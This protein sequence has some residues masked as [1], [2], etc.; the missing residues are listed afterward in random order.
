M[1]QLN[2]GFNPRCEISD[3][4]IFEEEFTDEGNKVMTKV[5]IVSRAKMDLCL[6]IY[7]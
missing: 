6:K 2:L 7:R 5:H 3:E 4:N 1:K